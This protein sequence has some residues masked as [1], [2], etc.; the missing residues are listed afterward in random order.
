MQRAILAT[1]LVMGLTEMP[2]MAQDV[3]EAAPAGE[4]VPDP[5]YTPRAG[6]RVHLIADPT[7][8]FS[9][10]SLF[11][12]YANFSKADDQDGLRAMID[13]GELVGLD[14]NVPVQVLRN[15]APEDVREPGRRYPVEV[16]VLVGTRA[17]E[18]WFVPESSVARLV[19][20][21]VHPPLAEGSLAT[22]ARPGTIVYAQW[23]AFDSA[24]RSPG[25]ATEE[26]FRLDKGIKV[27]ILERRGEAVRVR[28]HSGSKLS[29]RVGVVGRAGLR[30]IEPP[31]RPVPHRPASD[32]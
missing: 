28:V 30:S 16:R 32:R 6:D 23:D 2:T 19:P 3:K 25:A 12:D 29:G 31:S 13:K 27:V 26:S 22:I 20:K 21:V 1:I 11:D 24:T 9:R 10:D 15:L 8:G 17:G 4:M 7:P 18:V 5:S 14:V